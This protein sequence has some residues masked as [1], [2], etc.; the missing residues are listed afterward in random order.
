VDP[1]PP[2]YPAVLII[3]NDAST[4]ESEFDIAKTEK[5][6]ALLE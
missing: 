6:T 5:L 4:S 3:I 1:M 2:L